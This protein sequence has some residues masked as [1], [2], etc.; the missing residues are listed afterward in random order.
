MAAMPRKKPASTG[1]SLLTTLAPK[2][3]PVRQAVTR[4]RSL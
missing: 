2:P 1:T 3:M 4:V